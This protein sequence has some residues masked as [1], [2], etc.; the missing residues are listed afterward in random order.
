MKEQATV[1][2]LGK[3]DN[4]ALNL[5]YLSGPV[6][7][8]KNS[9]G[10]QV[11]DMPLVD[12]R[13][14]VGEN[15]AGFAVIAVA[16]RSVAPGTIT[17]LDSGFV[18]MSGFLADMKYLGATEGP[19]TFNTDYIS[20][21]VVFTNKLAKGVLFDDADRLVKHNPRTFTIVKTYPADAPVQQDAR[22]A[23]I[24]EAARM[25]IEEGRTTK[26]G[27]PEVEAIEQM[28]GDD[29]TAA[30]RDAAMDIITAE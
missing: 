29:I 27:K 16:G 13:K 18:D 7:F 26:S 3:S 19:I 22:M 30:E 25:A 2:Y 12:A 21:P 11:A 14:L 23:E 10:D 6:K 9:D 28:L 20:R 1:K 24:V 8:A 15:P 4:L 5:P 17:G